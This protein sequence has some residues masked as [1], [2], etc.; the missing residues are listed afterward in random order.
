MPRENRAGRWL[1]ARPLR[2][3]RNP[4]REQSLLCPCRRHVLVVDWPITRSLR[5]P[6]SRRAT[7]QQYF[8]PTGLNCFKSRHGGMAY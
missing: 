4:I 5:V 6:C 1:R 3:S 8:M 2:S 7:A